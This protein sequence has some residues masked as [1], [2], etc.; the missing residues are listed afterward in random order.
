MEL[1]ALLD[2]GIVLGDT[3][4]RQGFHEVDLMGR[5]QIHFL[6]EISWTATWQRTAHLKLKDSNGKC[7]RKEHDLA[8]RRHAGDDAADGALKV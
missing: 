3:L 5:T 6:R 8:G 4:Q 2:V 1:L 7:G